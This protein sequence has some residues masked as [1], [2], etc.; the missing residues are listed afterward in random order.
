VPRLIHLL[1]ICALVPVASRS[2][3]TL[4]IPGPGSVQA[5]IGLIS[6]WHCSA[7]RIEI[8]IDGGTPMLAGAH[9][10]RGDTAGVCGRSDT[11]FSMTYNWNLLPTRCFACRFHRVMALA[12]GVPFAFAEFEVENFGVEFLRGKSAQYELPNFPEAGS[13]TWLRWDEEKQNFSIYLTARDQ[14]GLGG[15][16]YGA[17]E[18]GARNPACG[19]FAPDRVLAVKH[20]TFSVGL[21]AGGV[22]FSAEYADGTACRLPA[23]AFEP[24]Q[25]NA[26]DGSRRAVF[27]AAAAC[28]EFPGGLELRVN[29]RRLEADSRDGCMSARVVGAQ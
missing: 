11:G 25:A 26:P 10:P 12:D 8:S 4:E 3:G 29:G 9:T 17:L 24:A 14:I 28:P 27:A 7:Q 18:S 1:L 5:G 15:R 20:G 13:L 16:Y 6:G 19:P 23:V 21:E 22:S 2:Q